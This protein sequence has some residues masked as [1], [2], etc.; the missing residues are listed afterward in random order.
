MED[1]VGL[2]FD[3]SSQAYKSLIL[4]FETITSFIL[5]D[6][7]QIILL[8]L[9]LVLEKANSKTKRFEVARNVIKD[10]PWSVKNLC[11]KIAIDFFKKTHIYRKV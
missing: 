4:L 11:G 9:L 10:L 7:I 1:S 5:D 3:L 8:P 6:S 2:Y